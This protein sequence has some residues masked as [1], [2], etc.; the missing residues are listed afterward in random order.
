[1]VQFSF[2]PFE[3]NTLEPNRCQLLF[4]T[5]I[6]S[7]YLLSAPI[8]SCFPK[9]FISHMTNACDKM[10]SSPALTTAM[11]IHMS[12]LT[13]PSKGFDMM[14]SIV[15][16]LWVSWSILLLFASFCAFGN[17]RS[18]SHTQM[19]SLTRVVTITQVENLTG[20]EVN[21]FM[22]IPTLI[23]NCTREFVHLNHGSV[24]CI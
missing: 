3:F 10:S 21:V 13:S 15:S 17:H 11:A 14:C 18:I 4:L 16:F 23:W 12:Q 24:A 1:M 19:L 7:L 2:R 22:T 6:L 5:Q 9:H 20:H 8:V